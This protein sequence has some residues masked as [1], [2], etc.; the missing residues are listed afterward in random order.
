MYIP[1]SKDIIKY[2]LNEDGYTF[3]GRESTNSK[4][5]YKVNSDGLRSIEFS[6]K[7]NII[8]LGCSITFGAGLKEEDIW[9][10]LLLTKIKN[11]GNF[12]IGSLATYGGSVMEQV[13]SFFN[14]I[15]KYDY[16]PKYVICNFPSLSRF[17][18]LSSNSKYMK[19]YFGK[20]HPIKNTIARYP[21][22]YE[23]IIPLEW[24]YYA[25]M[26][27]IKML[28]I[29]CKTNNIDLI[30]NVWSE[31]DK[32][33]F[34]FYSTNFNY[35]VQDP[36]VEIFPSVNENL[37][38]ITVFN[39]LPEKYKMKTNKNLVCHEEENEYYGNYYFNCAYDNKPVGAAK[40]YLPHPGVHR[41]LHWAE[42][43]F[44]NLIKFIEGKK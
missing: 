11:H 39:Q 20:V 22:E 37:E 16:V 18:F 4:Y 6:N 8:V 3:G 15:A 29:F 27:Y 19:R 31:L 12:S 33:M 28:E 42:F 17:Y 44:E 14:M 1:F 2:N 23:K 35:Y 21:L 36:T 5:S 41:H 30:W 10:S 13:S 26:E 34:D 32:D 40:E 43:Y 7:P 25:N 9:S 24:I 38:R